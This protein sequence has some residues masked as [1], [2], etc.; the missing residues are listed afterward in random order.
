M[1]Y[2][3]EYIEAKSGKTREQLDIQAI[4]DIK[5]YLGTDVAGVKRFSLLVE[6]ANEVNHDKMSVHQHNKTFGFAGIS[7]RQ[8]HAFCR[9]YCLEKLKEWYASTIGG[10]PVKYD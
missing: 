7:G 2:N 4:E 10:K 8:F 9:K 6:C 5:E 1:H 3:R